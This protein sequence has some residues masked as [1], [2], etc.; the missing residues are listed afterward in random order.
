MAEQLPSELF[1]LPPATT[2]LGAEPV[3][4][5]PPPMNPQQVEP[6]NLL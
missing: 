3:L 5:D 1:N 2:T 6:I 4:H